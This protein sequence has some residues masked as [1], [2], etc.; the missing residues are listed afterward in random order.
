M[1]GFTGP[2]SLSLKPRWPEPQELG[3]SLL[4]WQTLGRNDIPVPPSLEDSFYFHS[5]LVVANFW[6]DH[7]TG[8]FPARPSMTDGFCSLLPSLTPKLYQGLGGRKF[9][10]L[11]SEGE[12]LLLYIPKVSGIQTWKVQGLLASIPASPLV[13]ALNAFFIEEGSLTL[14]NDKDLVSE[15]RFPLILRFLGFPNCCASPHLAF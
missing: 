1:I 7:R 4:W 5:T 11:A 12:L 15:C 9:F 13:V 14:L 3:F 10:A 6:V 8:W 2:A